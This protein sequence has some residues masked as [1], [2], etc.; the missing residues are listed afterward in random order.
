MASQGGDVEEI[1]QR[2]TWWN[3]ATYLPWISNLSPDCYIKT[4]KK[5]KKKLLKLL[6]DFPGGLVVKNPPANARDTG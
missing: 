1:R 4:E 6:S 5:K 2:L 3:R